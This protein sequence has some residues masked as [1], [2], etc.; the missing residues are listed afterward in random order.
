[1][2]TIDEPVKRPHQSRSQPKER[3]V[4]PP[5]YTMQ[6][7]QRQALIQIAK[8]K[9]GREFL[10]WMVHWTG[11]KTSSLTMTEEGKFSHDAIQHN[12]SLRLMWVNLRRNL[13]VSLRNE[14]EMDMEPET[15]EN[16]KPKKKK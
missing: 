1:M 2:A 10:R 8:S 15:N 3:L 11:F 9:A 6:P 16:D 5:M 7:K 4:N 13:P 12:E 14:I